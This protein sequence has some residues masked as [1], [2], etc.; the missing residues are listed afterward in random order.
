MQE[1]GK[2]N[3]SPEHISGEHLR[4]QIGL[5]FH[6]GHNCIP[7]DRAAQPRNA[8]NID[9]S[10]HTPLNDTGMSNMSPY[11]AC[12]PVAQ[13]GEGILGPRANGLRLPLLKNVSVGR[14]FLK[15]F[16][17]KQRIGGSAAPTAWSE[18]LTLRTCRNRE[19]A[20][21]P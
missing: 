11:G 13:V 17:G 6:G 5:S 18:S 19:M 9:G 1:M 21:L 10:T 20:N 2:K 8:L 15:A 4:P 16:K 3:R 14:T 12:P 7:A